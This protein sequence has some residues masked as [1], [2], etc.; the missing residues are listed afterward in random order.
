MHGQITYGQAVGAGVVIFVYYSVIMA[1]YGYMLYTVIDPGLVKKSLAIAEEAMSKR[2]LP[3]AQI[4]TA[5]SMTA[6]FMNPVVMVISGFF[7]SL[8]FGVVYTLI[9][10][11]FVK[12][13]GNPLIDTPP[14]N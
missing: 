7:G 11:I 9:V 14:A 6:K 10:S 4:D 2:G 8:F 12:K 5:M 3:Q 13:E 1:A